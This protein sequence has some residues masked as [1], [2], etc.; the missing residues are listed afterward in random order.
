MKVNSLSGWKSVF[1]FTLGQTFKNK[2]FLITLFIL[3]ILSLFSM[4]LMHVIM[5]F[6]EDSDAIS[7]INK[8]YVLNET[9]LDTVDFNPTLEDDRLDHIV[10]ETTEETYDDLVKKVE[11]EEQ[12]AVILTMTELD[13]VFNLSLVK[14]S[15]GPVK[16]KHMALL[17]EVLKTEFRRSLVEEMEITDEQLALIDSS[18][19]TRVSHLDAD[20]SIIETDLEAISDSEYWFIYGLLFLVLMINIFAGTQVATSVVTEKSTKIVE[21]LLISVKPLALMVGK[22]I[23]MLCAVVL[24]MA[25][26]ALAFFLSNSMTKL[27]LVK[28]G[29]DL[30]G[31]F[32]P[33]GLFDNLN[34]FNVLLCVLLVVLGLIFY[35]ILAGLAGAT[36][37]KLEEISE[38]I[39]L[40]TFTNIAGMYVAMAASG[41]MMGVGSNGFVIFSYLF[42]LSSPF[43]LPGAIL[44]GEASWMIILGSLLLQVL[45]IILLF[46]FV[47]RV[48]ETLILH[49][50]EQVKLKALFKLSKMG[51]VAKH[52]D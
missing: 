49:N 22:I 23:A 5:S 19:R 20:G 9:T 35:S 25:A 47:A 45:S 13:G 40:F 26:V 21:T 17:M 37:S 12:D 51:K 38:G 39:S 6:G 41:I 15:E 29:E 44:I 10:F 43:I 48:Y 16:D 14:T 24:Q 28:E 42:P 52:E 30:I 27:F 11:D 8:V 36:V 4:P 50:G 32:L 34:F 3:I 2:A 33:E 18:I 31:S 7:P 46:K 1:T